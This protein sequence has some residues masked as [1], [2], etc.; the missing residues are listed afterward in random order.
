MDLSHI[1]NHLGENREEYHGAVSPPVYQ[2]SNFAFPNVAAMRHALPHEQEVSFYTR[3]LNPTTSILCQKLAALEG[4]DDALVF[5]SGVAAISAAVISQLKS[6]DHV[7]CVQKPYGWAEKLFNQLLGRFGVTVTYVDATDTGAIE[8]AIMPHTR[9]LY[10]ESPNSLTFELVDIEAV[11]KIAKAK[12]IVTVI[13][14]SYAT[15]LG[16]QPS[17][18]G[19]DIIIHSASKYLGGHSD[20][21][22]GVVCANKAIIKQIFDNEFMNL[23]G[24]AAPWT[25]SLLLRSLR[26]LPIRFERSTQS[27]AQVAAYLYS[28]PRVKQ[29]IYPGHHSHPQYA[30]AQ[31]QMGACGG[32]LS[33]LLDAKDVGEVEQFADKLQRFLLACSWGGHESL[34]LPVCALATSPEQLNPHLPWNLVR[35]Y[36]GLEDPQVLIDDL[37]QALG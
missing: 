13:D 32:L 36:I 9:M 2:T 31:K 6:G 17:K 11:C 24:I 16:Q 26:T 20:V 28:H 14:N 37:A 25:S 34:I 23:G 22:A 21:V 10:L 30:L 3:G 12:G 35:L 19:V 18:L 27:G 1:L 4:T 15:P 29:L 5:G 8:D 33:F 7:V